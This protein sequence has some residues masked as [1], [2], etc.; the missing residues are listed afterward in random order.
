MTE[1]QCEAH[2]VHTGKE[3]QTKS[4]SGYPHG[5]YKKGSNYYYNTKDGKANENAA[6]ICAEGDN[7]DLPEPEAPGCTDSCS[8]CVD[9][10]CISGDNGDMPEPEPE[11][12]GCTDSCSI[13]VDEV[14]ISGD[15][16]DMPEPEPEAP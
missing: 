5:C 4:S 16:G 15:N 1:D 14:C 2:A 8:I 10:V 11:A 6:P 9:E 12:P 7:S 13:C 3:F